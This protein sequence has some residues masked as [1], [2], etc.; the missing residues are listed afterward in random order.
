MDYAAALPEPRPAYLEFAKGAPGAASNPPALD[1]Q[2]AFFL[3][4][5]RTDSS[6]DNP[7][8]LPPAE[9]SRPESV[10]RIEGALAGR[11]LNPPQVLP[12]WTTNFV[13]GDSVVCFGVNRAGQVIS[14]A[15]QTGSGLQEADLS[16]L[17]TV[18]RMRFRPA[19]KSEPPVAWD[20]AT[21]YWK[22]AQPPQKNGE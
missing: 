14:V 11:Q 13:V 6:P 20:T 12:S 16:A 18:N 5:A 1:S 2:R 10:L 15:L 3:L 8:V 19:G 4:P 9:D 21:F 7:A 17:A 22:T